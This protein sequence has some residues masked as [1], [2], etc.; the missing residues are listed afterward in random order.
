MKKIVLTAMVFAFVANVS[1]QLK[2]DAAG[3]TRATGNIYLESTSNFLGTT[4]SVVPVT[5]K[6]NGLL[7][8]S[9]GR[10][11]AANVSFGYG[12]LYL[13]TTGVNN[14]AHG[15]RTLYAN[16]TGNACTA[17]GSYTLCSNTTGISNTGHGY[18]VL[19]ANTT[20]NENTAYGYAALAKSTTG[21]Y[22]IANGAYVLHNTQYFHS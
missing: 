9:T 7:A 1:A 4:N 11:G 16:T 8:G 12:A 19:A 2:V 20:G 21:G 22:N 6:V 15:Y 10:S 5:F 13:N 14:N 17:T 18:G 3:N